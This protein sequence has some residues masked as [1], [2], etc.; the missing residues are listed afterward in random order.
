MKP[1]DGPFEPFG[2]RFDG[3]EIDLSD[4]PLRHRLA[5]ALWDQP[6]ASPR[7]SRPISEVMDEV[8]P[9]EADADDKLKDLWK[10]LNRNFLAGNVAVKVRTAGGK[11]WL[12]RST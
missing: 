10:Q 7:P 3:R 4:S 11:L 1:P 6:S 2:F 12:A 5:V 8:Y 9:R